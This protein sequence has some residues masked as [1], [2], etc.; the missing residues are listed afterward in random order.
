M[1][2][3]AGWGL[4]PVY[5]AI[6]V[7]CSVLLRL[8]QRHVRCLAERVAPVPDQK[9]PWQIKRKCREEKEKK[10]L[11]WCHPVFINRPGPTLANLI[12]V[13]FIIN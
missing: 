8:A 2:Y 11:R 10:V 5:R 6:R 7:I 1:L 12:K 13:S 4:R 3:V 9:F